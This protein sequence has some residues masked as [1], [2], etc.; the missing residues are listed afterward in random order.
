MAEICGI[1]RLITKP[2]EVYQAFFYVNFDQDN[3]LF[4]L[5]ASFS[6]MIVFKINTSSTKS[7]VDSIYALMSVRLAWSNCLIPALDT[8]DHLVTG[9]PHTDN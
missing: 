6:Y 9:A 8:L 3:Q 4:V 7:S 5:F 1:Y 2:V